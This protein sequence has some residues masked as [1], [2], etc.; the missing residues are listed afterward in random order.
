FRLFSTE[1]S[2]SKSGAHLQGTLRSGAPFALPL[3]LV[4]LESREKLTV[5]PRYPF[6][7]RCS[8]ALA[9][10]AGL[11][12]SLP[13]A[14]PLLPAPSGALTRVLLPGGWRGRQGSVLSVAFSPD[15]RFVASG[16]WDGSVLLWDVASAA[17][18]TQR[19]TLSRQALTGL[20]ADLESRDAIRGH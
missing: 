16:G 5:M 3:L 7:D 13:A 8:F 19:R 4:I 9:L 20:W 11:A 17:G 6:P 15:G 2:T 14:A 1:L 12:P 10:L 18:R